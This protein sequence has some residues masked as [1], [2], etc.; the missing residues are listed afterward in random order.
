[1]SEARY[2]EERLEAGELELPECG[3]LLESAAHG[4]VTMRSS[5]RV[6][7]AR[8]LDGWLTEVQGPVLR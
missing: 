3:Y 4:E 1:M 5:D 7:L 2:D 8:W 6:C